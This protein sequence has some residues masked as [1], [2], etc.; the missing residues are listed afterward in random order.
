MTRD[1]VLDLCASLPGAVE[2]QPFGDGVAV[3]KVGRKMFALVPLAG[4]PDSVNLKCDPDWALELRAVYAAV[5]PGYHMNKRHW[6]TVELDGSVDEDE[7]RVMVEHSY[8]LVV[9]RLPRRER[10]GLTGS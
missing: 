9:R 1:Q 7:L 10:D 4:E 6:N 8:E 2:D 3:F 5:R